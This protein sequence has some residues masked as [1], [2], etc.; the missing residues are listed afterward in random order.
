MIY[1]S[2]QAEGKIVLAIVFASCK[3]KSLFL[4]ANKTIKIYLGE[5]LLIFIK[6]SSA[7]QAPACDTDTKKSLLGISLKRASI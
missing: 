4:S 7:K 6:K 5:M 1:F 2:L 3:G